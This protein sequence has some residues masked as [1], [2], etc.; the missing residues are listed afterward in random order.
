MSDNAEIREDDFAGDEAMR[1]LMERYYTHRVAKVS[2]SSG[3]VHFWRPIA[4]NVA[5]I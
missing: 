2:E 5:R 1:R 3:R 4:A